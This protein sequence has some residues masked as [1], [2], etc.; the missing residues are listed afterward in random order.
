[1]LG[2]LKDYVSPVLEFIANLATSLAF[3]SATY[4]F[5]TK[6]KQ[7][8]ALY[9]VLIGLRNQESYRDLTRKL[10]HLDR[11]SADIKEQKGEV[12]NLLADVLGQLRINPALCAAT[13]D[14][15][16]RLNLI[17]SGKSK[18]NEMAKRQLCSE[19][20]EG[21]RGLSYESVQSLT[22]EKK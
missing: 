16:S 9:N 4:L 14:L 8:S 12:Q 3:V 5:F 2:F 21:L 11:L 19:L 15:Q 7:I 13:A 6:K 18:L 1:M 10:D 22:E 17:I 20:R